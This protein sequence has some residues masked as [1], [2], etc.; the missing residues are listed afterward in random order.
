MEAVQDNARRKGLQLKTVFLSHCTWDKMGDIL[1]NAGGRC[2]RLFDELVSFFS[3]MNMY[4]SFKMQV[5]LQNGFNF[6]YTK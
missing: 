2:F 4:S 6:N 1:A 5:R 3:A